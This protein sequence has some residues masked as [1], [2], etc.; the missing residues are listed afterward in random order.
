MRRIG[1]GTVRMQSGGHTAFPVDFDADVCNPT[2]GNV[3]S[4]RIEAINNFAAFATNA[5]GSARVLEV[6]IPPLPRAF[7]HERPFD[8]LEV[9]AI[10]AVRVI[11][12]RFHLGQRTIVCA[13]QIA[14]HKVLDLEDDHNPS[15]SAPVKGAREIR[16]MA[17]VHEPSV[18]AKDAESP[19][20][21]AGVADVDSA[22]E[23][24]DV[25][26]ASPSDG[27]DDE[28]L[29]DAD[30]VADAEGD[31]ED[32]E[33][34]EYAH[35]EESA[36]DADVG[37]EEEADIDVEED[38]EEDAEEDDEEDGDEVDDSENDED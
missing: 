20:T 36:A 16:R 4:C 6:I 15:P 11:G 24:V 22:V 38:A 30:D 33:D 37:P 1:A 28:G 32:D 2:I 8:E 18:R 5:S 7:R 26:A 10:A 3:F 27:A 31:E 25:E 21:E 29:E 13:G 14:A 19:D 9:G 12:K 23:E 17:S 34:D 35:E